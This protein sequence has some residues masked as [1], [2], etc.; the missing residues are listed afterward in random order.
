[1]LTSKYILAIR[2]SDGADKPINFQ[3]LIDEDDKLIGKY[4]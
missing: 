2:E 1:M 3:M 4:F